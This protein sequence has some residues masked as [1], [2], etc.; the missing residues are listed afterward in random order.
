VNKAANF[1]RDLG[2]KK[3]DH[4]CLFLPNCP[5]FLYLWFGLSKIGALMLPIDTRLR[6][7]ELAYVINNSDS[8][9]IVLNEVLYEVFG[10]VERNLK[11]IEKKFGI[12][13]ATH[14]RRIITI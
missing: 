12:V 13:R 9:L 1:F 14:L 8:K 3:G 4:V 5:E 11:G 7:S 6:E 10:F 2:V